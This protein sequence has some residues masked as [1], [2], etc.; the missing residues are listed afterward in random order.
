[1]Q[2]H[3]REIADTEAACLPT[4]SDAFASDAVGAIAKPT[5][6]TWAT[7]QRQLLV[8]L[9]LIS[10]DVLVASAAWQV[11]IVLQ[12]ILGQGETSPLVIAAL[13]PNTVVWIGL[14]ASLGLYPGYGLGSVEELRR[15]TL[16]LLATLTITL[17]FAFA[18]QTGDL[19]SRI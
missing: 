14:R 13:L 8:V 6:K 3:A 2:M 4:G 16:A 7:S 12:G 19:L 5:K 11:A 9:F 17:V 15:Q 10:S 1:M 18:S